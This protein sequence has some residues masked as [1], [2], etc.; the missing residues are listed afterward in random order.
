M[1]NA[2]KMPIELELVKSELTEVALEE[3]LPSHS[4]IAREK[5]HAP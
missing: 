5:D 2:V 1:G 3:I 4:E